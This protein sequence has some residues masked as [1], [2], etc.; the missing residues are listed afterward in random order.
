LDDV[1]IAVLQAYI[2]T[3]LILLYYL[4]TGGRN[5]LVDSNQYLF[6]GITAIKPVYIDTDDDSGGGSNRPILPIETT[7]YVH[8]EVQLSNNPSEYIVCAGEIDTDS[9]EPSPM[10]FV[11]K[12][13]KH[14]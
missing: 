6:I 14:L 10:G 13:Y 1:S 7:I 11:A 12:I 4:Y 3:K 5:I 9:N 8:F 2:F